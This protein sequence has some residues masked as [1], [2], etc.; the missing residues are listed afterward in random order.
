M[1]KKSAAGSVNPRPSSSRGRAAVSERAFE[2][3]IGQLARSL[4]RATADELDA[5]INTW[6]KRILL[7]LGLDR[8]TIAE[9]NP[10][11]GSARFIYGWAREPDRLIS[12][13]LDPNIL[14]PWTLRKM[15]AGETVVMESP[16]KLPQGAEVDRDSFRRYGPKSN[17]MVPIRIGDTVIGAVSFASLHK[18]REWLPTVVRGLEAIGDIF[19]YALERKRAVAE[20]MRLRVELAYMSR[21]S[22][23]GQLTA[24]IAHQLNQPLG[25]ILSNAEAMQSLLTVDSPDLDEMR[26]GLADIVADTHRVVDLIRNL[27]ELFQRKDLTKSQIDLAE[28]IGEINRMVR[29]DAVI[30]GIDF[31]TAMPQVLPKVFGHR[32][33]L[34]EA[35]LN[36]ISNA[37]DAAAAV[38]GGARKVRLAAVGNNGTVRIVVSDSGAGISRDTMP[39]IFDSFFTTKP[40]GVGIGLGIAKSI[41]E[42]HG[43]VLSAVPNPER[44][45]TFEIALPV[46][47]DRR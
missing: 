23:V 33:Q 15:L 3:L 46:S 29:Q 10:A 47:Q 42:A 37:F 32:I 40:T 2:T 45:M 26:A 35:L 20:S 9:I 11:T 21:V 30:R 7:T 18:E 31:V 28:T 12:E 8:S 44:G 39:R 43:G 36:L 25:A 14:L 1:H 34:Q 27:R 13:P 22:T 16:E 24:A 5:E 38:D 17:V 19:S 41:V 6:L 4:V